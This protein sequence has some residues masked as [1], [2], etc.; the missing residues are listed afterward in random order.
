MVVYLISLVY[1]LY[2]YILIIIIKTYFYYNAY[3]V[4]ELIY[5][6]HGRIK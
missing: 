2:I 3:S 1:I 5:N 4:I 6:N